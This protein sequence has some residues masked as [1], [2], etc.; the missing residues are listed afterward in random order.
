MSN[1]HED[2]IVGMTSFDVIAYLKKNYDMFMPNPKDSAPYLL[3]RLMMDTVMLSGISVQVTSHDGW[4]LVACNVDWIEYVSRSEDDYFGAIIPFPAAGDNA[5]HSGILLSAFATDVALSL[6]GK[7]RVV[8]GSQPDLE[9][10]SF[11]QVYF[12]KYVRVV[13][14]RYET[15]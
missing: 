12:D 3:G 5:M 8:K 14:Y 13:L 1:Y 2:E 4:W 10:M 9:T 6:S 15:E 7:F 11:F